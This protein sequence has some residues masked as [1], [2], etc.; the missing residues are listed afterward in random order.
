MDPAK[1]NNRVEEWQIK[2]IREA[3]NQRVKRDDGGNILTHPKDIK[4][5][6]NIKQITV[7]QTAEWEEVKAA[8][9]HPQKR[10]NMKAR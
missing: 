4:K 7:K 5:G 1:V 2:Q 6:K 3:T 10:E 9:R 8:C